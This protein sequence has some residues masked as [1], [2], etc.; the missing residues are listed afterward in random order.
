MRS[1]SNTGSNDLK[2]TPDTPERGFVTEFAPAEE[3]LYKCVQCGFCLSACPT[4][5]ETGLEAESPRGRLTLMK[6]V[7]ERRIE[8]TPQV[9][10]HWDLCLECRACEVACPSG[11]PYGKIMMATRAEM[12]ERVK[13]PFRERFAR[14]VGFNRLLAR[15]KLMR[16][17]GRMTRFYQSSGMRT[18]TQRIGVMKVL[19][20]RYRYLDEAMPPLESSF[21]VPDGRV[22]KPMGQIKARVALLGGCAMSMMHSSTMDATVRVLVHNGFEVHVPAGQG[23]CGSMNMYAGERPTGLEMA[24]NNVEALL[25]V[26]PDVV[27]TS[28][29]GCGSTMKE[30]GEFLPDNHAAEELADKTRDIHELLDEYG[31]AVPTG[32]IETKVVF[33]DPCHLLST[34]RISDAPRRVLE[35]IPGVGLV[36]MQEPSVCCGS[37]GSYA[38]SQREMSMRLGDRKARNVVASGANV[39]ATGNPGCALQLTNALERANSGV[40]VSYVVDWLYAAD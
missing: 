35:A 15:P 11:V 34:Q 13:R 33:Q 7:N 18:L 39:M 31:F 23:C 16:A 2:S 9:T 6:A 22:V 36:A 32:R 29:A 25:A 17:F 19:P 10:R 14:E 37:A 8:I 4:Y 1:E 27:V 40:R 20:K 28:S 38:I 5:L 3:D 12:K 24:A 30:Y 21:F 26:D